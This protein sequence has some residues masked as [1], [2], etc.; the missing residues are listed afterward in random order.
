[1]AA[2]GSSETAK[3]FGELGHGVFTYSLLQA[4]K[5]KAVMNKM[6]T[7]N[8]LKNYLQEIVPELVKKYGSSGQYPASYGFGNDFPLEVINK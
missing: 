1:M 4:L 2:S 7:V 3:E 6:I 5:G 8:G